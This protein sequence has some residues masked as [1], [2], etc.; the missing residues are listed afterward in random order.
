MDGSSLS[1]ILIPIVVAI[2]LAAWLVMVAHAARHPEW[3]HGPAAPQGARTAPA[4]SGQ[5]PLPHTK[6]PRP[7]RQPAATTPLAA[8]GHAGR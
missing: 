2:S 8:A 3:K 5:I 7:M 1:L 6:I 4:P